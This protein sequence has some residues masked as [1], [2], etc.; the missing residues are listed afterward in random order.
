M[1]SQEYKNPAALKATFGARVDFLKGNITIFDV[2][3]NKFRISARVEYDF[4]A[5]YVRRVMTHEEYENA[6]KDETL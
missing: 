4:Q 2:G 5:T 1:E 3:G 6:I